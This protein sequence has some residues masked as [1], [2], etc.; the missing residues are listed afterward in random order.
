MRNADLS[1]RIVFYRHEESG[2]IYR[3]HGV[4]DAFDKMAFAP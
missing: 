4:I 2:E 3:L 1:R